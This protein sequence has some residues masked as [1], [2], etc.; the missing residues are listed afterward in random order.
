MVVLGITDT[1]YVAARNGY[2]HILQYAHDHGCPWDKSTCNAA[3]WKGH[4]PTLKYL[5]ENGC[6]RDDGI[7]A[8]MLLFMVMHMS[9][10]G[11]WIPFVLNPRGIRVMTFI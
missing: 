3:A 1:C 11:L 2:L 7:Y 5:H 4:I 8:I 10:I 6:P 9:F